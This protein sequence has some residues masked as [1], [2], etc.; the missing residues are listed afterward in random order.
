MIKSFRHKGLAEFFATGRSKK[1][2]P[3]HREKVRMILSLLNSITHPAQMAAPG[4]RYHPLVRGPL[5]GQHAV[6][7]DG[8]TRIWFK[9]ENGHATE[10]DYGDYH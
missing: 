2:M 10:V 9:F 6:D 7:V 4:L 1:I 3:K 8:N 5:A